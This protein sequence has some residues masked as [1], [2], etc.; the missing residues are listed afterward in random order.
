MKTCETKEN[1][2]KQSSIYTE[3][4]LLL[5]IDSLPLAVAVIDENMT[6]SL[7]NTAACSM[8]NKNH[9]HLIGKTGGQALECANR[10][11]SPEGCGFGPECTKCKLRQTL[12]NTMKLNQPYKMVETSMAFKGRDRM[13]M[14]LSTL[15][16][17]I[18]DYKGVL[19]SIEDI[20]RQKEYDFAK[21]EN[22][23]LSAAVQTAG[24]ICHEMNQPLM[25]ILGFSELLIEDLPDD[26][27]HKDNL[28][29]IKKQAGRLG[30]ITAKL[31]K[32]TR[33]RTKRYLNGDILDIDAGSVDEEIKC[34]KSKK[35]EYL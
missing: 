1:P 30:R 13:Y 22:E 17:Q 9:E 32:L 27:G 3:E 2:E 10:H 33:Y 23:K 14:R 16:L 15:P 8:F 21:T 19:L 5:L 20:T 11:D 18:S 12:S 29:E 35:G 26:S 7:A 28:L 4:G 24:A 6:V 25:S 31:M 34:T